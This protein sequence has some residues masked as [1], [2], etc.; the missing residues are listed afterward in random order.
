MIFMNDGLVASCQCTPI[1]GCS[2]SSRDQS[3]AGPGSVLR[4]GAIS[5][6][7]G[8]SGQCRVRQPQCTDEAG[9]YRVLG[10]RV[11]HVVRPL[12]LDPDRE[13][14]AAFTALERRRARMPGA[15][16]ERDELHDL[17][18]AADQR[19]RRDLQARDFLEVGVRAGIEPVAEQRL[20][21]RATE[22]P[23]RQRD[24]VHD[25]QLGYRAN[26]ARIL[27]G[28]G[29]LAR[30]RHESGAGIDDDIAGLRGL[31]HGLMVLT[32]CA[33]CQHACP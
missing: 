23:G 4:P 9:E 1:Q 17:A 6:D 3:N 22:L 32:C 5:P 13:I 10:L 8:R 24:S 20:D 19:V 16:P 27:I 33:R 2:E 30:G 29:T 26:G 12:E 15:A 21:V 28:R 25:D 31:V 7:D 18:V 11:G 14:V